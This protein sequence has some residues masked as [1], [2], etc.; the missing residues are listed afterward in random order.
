[1]QTQHLNGFRAHA[2]S[3]GGALARKAGLAFLLGLLTTEGFAAQAS[4]TFDVRVS[5]Q[6]TASVPLPPNPVPPGPG[7]GS[8][9]RSGNSVGN[10]LCVSTTSV[11]AFGARA[12]VVC[13]TGA[14][15]DLSTVR[16]DN[17]QNPLHG[18]AMRFVTQVFWNGDWIDSIDDTPRT[19]TVTTWRRVN[20]ANSQYLELTVGW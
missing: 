16:N 5:L 17:P 6:Q 14:L 13:S 18:G 2:P 4:N 8:G 3:K 10:G 12:T 11:N 20:L 1:M 7:G 19:G 15:V 9:S